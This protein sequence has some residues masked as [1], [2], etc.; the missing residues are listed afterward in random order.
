MAWVGD[1]AARLTNGAGRRSSAEESAERVIGLTRLRLD[2]LRIGSMD[3]V[4]MCNNAT[5][6]Q[7]QHNLLT[8]IESLEFFSQLQFLVLSHN[9]IGTIEGLAHLHT[10]H[11]LDLSHN[12]IAEVEV[13]ALPPNLKALELHGNPLL[14]EGCAVV[15]S[16]LRGGVTPSLDWIYL[17]R[18]HAS[19]AAV[20]ELREQLYSAIRARR[21]NQWLEGVAAAL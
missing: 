13:G 14:D 7:L 16:A 3:G 4:E 10:L 8:R 11:Y 12:C 15:A 1:D 20:T 21:T 9:Q 2:R 18:N 6:L 5:H 19:A 17:G